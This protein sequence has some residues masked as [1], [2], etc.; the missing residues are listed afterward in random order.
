M[1][2]NVPE[3][4]EEKIKKL[5]LLGICDLIGALL[6]TLREGAINQVFVLDLL[7]KHAV[8]FLFKHYYYG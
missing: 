2:L 6:D 1:L 5:V 8:P 7:D 4:K 3:M